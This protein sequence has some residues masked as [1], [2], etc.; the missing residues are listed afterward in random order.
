M[1]DARVVDLMTR[2]EGRISFEARLADATR[3]APRHSKLWALG[4]VGYPARD[5]GGTGLD[6][7]G[8]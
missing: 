3:L 7:T 6:Q 8:E 4:R 5:D 2:T 1:L